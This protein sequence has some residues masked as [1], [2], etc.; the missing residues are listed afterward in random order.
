MHMRRPFLALV[1]LGALTLGA[2]RRN[3]PVPPVGPLAPAVDTVAQRLAREAAARDAAARAAAARDSAARAAATPATDSA[4]VAGAEARRILTT[5]VFFA[6]DASELSDEARQLLDAKLAVLQR[7]PTVAIRIAGHTDARGATEY[8]L[9][10][11]LRRASAVR[12]YLTDR[13]IAASRVAVVSFGAERPLAAGE[14]EEAWAQNRRDEFEITG[15]DAALG[16]AR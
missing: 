4:A 7:Y 11:G 16:R 6:F 3:Q 1:G 10:L 8:N 13:G 9:A 2:C 12:K 14:S 15:G 5:P